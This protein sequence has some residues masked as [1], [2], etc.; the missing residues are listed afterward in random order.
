M[1]GEVYDLL[2]QGKDGYWYSLDDGTLDHCIEEARRFLAENEGDEKPRVV[3]CP[4]GSNEV[5]WP[6][7]RERL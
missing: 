4:A 5:V 2:T 1:S 7:K 6:V 3:I